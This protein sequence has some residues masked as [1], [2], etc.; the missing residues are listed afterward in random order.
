MP[1]ASEVPDFSS[2]AFAASTA[3]SKTSATAKRS[4]QKPYKRII[5]LTYICKGV[6]NIT[7]SLIPYTR[8]GPK[9]KILCPYLEF[10]IFLRLQ[11][12]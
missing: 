12:V 5:R 11:S 8:T 9:I 6:K 7:D 3:F 4:L 2:S 1:L 10:Q